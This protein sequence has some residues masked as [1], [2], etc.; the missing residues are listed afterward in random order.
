M[1]SAI[2]ALAVSS[3]PV[4]ATWGAPVT[5]PGAIRPST[6]PGPYV[7]VPAKPDADG[8]EPTPALTSLAQDITDIPPGAPSDDYGLVGWCQGALTGHMSLYAVVR[9]ELKKL[10]RAGEA[11]ADAD[12]E[13]AQMQAGREYL[14]L[15]DRARRAADARSA[16]V[17]KVR[18]E[19]AR[20]AGGRIWNEASRADPQTRMWSWIMWELPARCE[21][22]ARRLEADQSREAAIIS[23]HTSDDVAAHPHSPVLNGPAPNTPVPNGQALNDGAQN[24]GATSISPSPR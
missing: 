6:D 10:S 7:V 14:D 1:L 24:P 12:M 11:K 19:V 13:T 20:D 18:G 22:A 9:P 16:G 21:T 17:D 4:I 15:Y 5:A 8:A 3:P 23:R 2:L